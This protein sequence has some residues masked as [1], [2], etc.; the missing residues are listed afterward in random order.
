[1]KL[2]LQLT[3][4]DILGS[5]AHAKMLAH[6][7][8]LTAEEFEQLKAE[9]HTLYQNADEVTLADGVED[10]HSQV[11]FML[12]QKLGDTGKKLHSGRSRNDQV[13]LDLKLFAREEIRQVEAKTRA[14]FHTFIEQSEAYKNVLM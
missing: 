10:I 1:R 4:Y 11:E 14:L 7:G 3:R 2:D 13:L 8:L 12:T 5:V 6:I 9:L